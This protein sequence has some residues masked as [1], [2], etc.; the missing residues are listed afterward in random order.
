[1]G[2]VES[3]KVAADIFSPVTGTISAINDKVKADA[4]LVN[5]NAEESW[6]I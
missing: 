6:L 4:S 2:A 5:K 3:V 1:L